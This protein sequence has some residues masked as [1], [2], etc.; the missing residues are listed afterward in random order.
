MNALIHLPS[1]ISDGLDFMIDR[2]WSPAQALAVVELLAD[3]QARIWMHYQVE[4]H[5]LIREQRVLPD[6]PHPSDMDPF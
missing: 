1:G 5:E 3:L 4:L 2:N 6:H